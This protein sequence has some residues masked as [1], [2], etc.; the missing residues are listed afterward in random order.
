L[1]E[2]GSGKTLAFAIPVLQSLLEN[3]TYYYALVMAPTRYYKWFILFVKDYVLKNIKTKNDKKIIS[4][5]L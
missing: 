4:K 1:A 3:P 2:T 5:C